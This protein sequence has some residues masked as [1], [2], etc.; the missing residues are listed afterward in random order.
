MGP[1]GKEP[2]DVEL[3]PRFSVPDASAAPW[4]EARR[5]LAEAELYWLTTLRPDGSPHTTPLVAVWH[6]DR[7]YFCS[8]PGERKVRNLELDPRCILM[9]GCNH[10]H[11]GLDIVVE[12]EAT[13]VTRTDELARVAAAYR[14]KYPEQWHFTVGDDVLVGTAGKAWAYSMAPKVAFGFAKGEFAQTRWRFG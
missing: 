1:M 3:D 11:R 7:L 12:A 13:R 5:L 9:T 2:F 6:D 10:L 4:S 14:A 8:T